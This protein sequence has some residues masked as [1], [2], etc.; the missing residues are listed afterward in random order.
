V[1]RLLGSKACPVD[2]TVN[3][4]LLDSIPYQAMLN[5]MQPKNVGSFLG[6]VRRRQ[7][8]SLHHVAKRIGR[9]GISKQA[10]SLIERGRMK[11][12]R[13]R[14][15][16]LRRA[17]RMSV[18]EN[19]ELARLYAFETM[20]ENTGEDREFGE[21]VLSVIDP[22][23]TNSIYI[24]GGRKLALTSP[25]LQAKAAKFLEGDR[26]TLSFFYPKVDFRSQPGLGLWHHNTERE[27]FE[28]REAIRAISPKSVAR[29]IRF[30]EIDVSMAQTAPIAWQLLSL[31]SPFTTTTIAS[32]ASLGHAVGYIY[33]EGPR[34]RWVLLKPE[35]AKRAAM[36]LESAMEIASA[37]RGPIREH[38][39][40]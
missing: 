23:T 24:L 11:V 28:L 4:R 6:N 33:V 10:L 13:A 7:Q 40:R 36:V 14:L 39:D 32:S 37:E 12:P 35:H 5:S 8:R 16:L 29:K 25:T 20:I 3:R 26:N 1:T 27:R 38:V 18:T 19:E 9:K 31:C 30:I 15:E 2:A 17:Y 34:D 22:K 21:A